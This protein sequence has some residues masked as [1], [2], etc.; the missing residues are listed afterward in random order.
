MFSSYKSGC[1]KLGL[2]GVVEIII[3][4]KTSKLSIMCKYV[5]SRHIHHK[6][7][8]HTL[9]RYVYICGS[10]LPET[11]PNRLDCIAASAVNADCETSAWKYLC[12]CASVRGCVQYVSEADW[13]WALTKVSIRQVGAVGVA[14]VGKVFAGAAVHGARLGYGLD[15]VL[16]VRV[17]P[18][19]PAD[20]W[21]AA[22]RNHSP[23]GLVPMWGRVEA[24][25]ETLETAF[26]INPLDDCYSMFYF[27]T[28]V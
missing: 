7:V 20:L 23:R 18:A 2:G 5:S 17:P 28:F 8:W 6:S 26:T 19:P 3:T 21:L 24:S 4:V 22:A 14:A 1:M 9:M 11:S 16:V 13:V 10:L 27:L 15:Q 12:V 25:R